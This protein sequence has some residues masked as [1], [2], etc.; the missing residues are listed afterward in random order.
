MHASQINLIGTFH[1]NDRFILDTCADKSNNVYV[2]FS[3]QK[4]IAKF[5]LTKTSPQRFIKIKNIIENDF[6]PTAISC[7]DHKIYVSTRIDNYLRVYD[8]MLKRIDQIK[9]D[10]VIVSMHQN[11]AMSSKINIIA[12]GLDAVGL[13]DS[14][15][16]T[17]HFYEHMMCIKDVD[18]YTEINS[19]LSS[20]YVVDSCLN[21]VL[22]FVTSIQ[23][24]N[25]IIRNSYSIVSGK[26]I[27]SIRNSFHSLVVLTE[28]PNKIMFISL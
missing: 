4:E 9:I 12:D 11:L 2:L 14:S 20:I 3:L 22:N 19:N 17:C 24:K 10:N 26:P 16:Q 18:V 8:S 27:A 25:I 7:T 1:F 5:T 6:Q 23:N 28:K 15:N 13:I 21:K